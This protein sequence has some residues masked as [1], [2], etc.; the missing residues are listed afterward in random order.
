LFPSSLL[1]STFLTRLFDNIHFFPMSQKENNFPKFIALRDRFLTKSLS[2][3]IFSCYS[4]MFVRLSVQR[5][6]TDRDVSDRI[7]QV[8]YVC[9][10]ISLHLD[11]VWRKPKTAK[12]LCLVASTQC[13]LSD[14]YVAIASSNCYFWSE[15]AVV[16][17]KVLTVVNVKTAVFWH[18][19]PCSL[20]GS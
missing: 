7:S 3:L 14:N 2:F 18:V 9:V 4:A 19:T 8:K 10:K 13:L 6:L 20:I 16:K 12:V 15:N 17:F 5:N 11:N 1:P